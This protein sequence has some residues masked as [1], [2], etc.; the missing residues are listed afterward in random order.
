MHWKAKLSRCNLEL[1]Q[2]DWRIIGKLLKNAEKKIADIA[3]ELKISARTVIKRRVNMTMESSVFL[4]H[5]VRDHKQVR[6]ALPCQL[7]VQCSAAEKSMIDHLIISKDGRIFFD[8]TDS[9]TYSI[10]MVICINL[11]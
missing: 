10:F 5:P 11:A 2:T 8:L 1:K 7:V 4:L 6:G 9:T 3:Y